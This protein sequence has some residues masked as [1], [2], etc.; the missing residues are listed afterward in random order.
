M[1][2]AAEVETRV[3]LDEVN[4]DRLLRRQAHRLS[5]VKL[6]HA[7]QCVVEAWMATE[8]QCRRQILRLL[9]LCETLYS[10][11]LLNST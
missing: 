8:D 6:V 5:L 4:Q 3:P 9:L 7:S 1:K 2:M 11:F 10:W